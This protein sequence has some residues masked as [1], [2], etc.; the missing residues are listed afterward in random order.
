[1]QV[2]SVDVLD[3]R[4]RSNTTEVLVEEDA[5]WDQLGVAA[6]Q[7]GDTDELHAGARVG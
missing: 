6:V 3:D 5:G 2:S 4:W 1:M 7:V